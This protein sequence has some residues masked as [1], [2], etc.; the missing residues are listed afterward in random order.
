MARAAGATTST[1]P[2]RPHLR[3]R[4]PRSRWE[5]GTHS[6]R[7][8]P[9]ASS[10]VAAP[11]VAVQ[12]FARDEQAAV[13]LELHHQGLS[14]RAIADRVPWSRSTV[15]RMLKKHGTRRPGTQAP[16]LLEAVHA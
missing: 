16:S 4:R 1:R 13:I 9:P 7:P 12:Q 5:P 10:A 3:P 8:R 15:N 2:R 11:D 6:P 14:E